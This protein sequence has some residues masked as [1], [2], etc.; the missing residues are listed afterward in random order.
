MQLAG[1]ATL[2][3]EVP[4]RVDEPDLVPREDVADRPKHVVVAVR[5]RHDA[6]RLRQAVPLYHVASGQ[7]VL[8]SLGH[9]LIEGCCSDVDAF[10]AGE[11]VRLDCGD[12]VG[13]CDDERRDLRRS[14]SAQQATWTGACSRWSLLTYHP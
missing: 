7:D 3:D 2:L 13:D 12:C 6:G 11:V 8:D 10:D 5:H 9:R 4:V 1:A 14:E